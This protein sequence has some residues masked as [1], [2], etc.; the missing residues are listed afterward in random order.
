MNLKQTVNKKECKDS[1]LGYRYAFVV[2]IRIY[3]PYRFKVKGSVS[4]Q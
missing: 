4:I 1:Q 2:K 3:D